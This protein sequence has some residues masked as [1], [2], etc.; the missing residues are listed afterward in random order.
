MDLMNHSAR[1][2]AALIRRKEVSPVEAVQSAL[3][4]IA[5]RPELN[6]FIT[7]TA[8]QALDAARV[9]EAGVMAGGELPRCM[10]CRTR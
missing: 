8:E 3:D 9:A 5:A 10:A 4:R 2:L 1:D 6:A 7:V